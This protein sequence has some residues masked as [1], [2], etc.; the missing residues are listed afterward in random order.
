M[1][2]AICT[3]VQPFLSVLQ[4]VGFFWGIEAPPVYTWVKLGTVFPEMKGGREH[5]DNIL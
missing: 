5:F 2:T 3:R 4:A 1:Q